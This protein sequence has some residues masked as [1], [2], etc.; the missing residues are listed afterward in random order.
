MPK[1]IVWDKKKIGLSIPYSRM[2]NEGPLR[3]IFE[4]IIVKNGK[5][6]NH[7]SI[8]KIHKLLNLHQ[9]SI[10]DQDHSNTLWRILS[11]ELW[12]RSF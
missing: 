9:P 7:F 10:Q 6:S 11:L 4:E 2:L 3:N 8:K 12:L 1:S 5:L